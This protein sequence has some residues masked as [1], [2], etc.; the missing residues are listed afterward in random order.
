MPTLIHHKFTFDSFKLFI[1]LKYH[2]NIYL[3]NCKNMNIIFLL[4]ASPKGL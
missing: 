4:N 3:N 2:F 1:I